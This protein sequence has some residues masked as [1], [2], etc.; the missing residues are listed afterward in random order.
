[1]HRPKLSI[2]VPCYNEALTLE[3]L[4]GRVTAAAKAEV[5]EDYELVLI[6]DGSKDD[7]WS[8]MRRLSQSDPRLVAI[9]G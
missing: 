9:R 1:M 7:S 8:I 6:N 3:T 2:V 4:H 5:G